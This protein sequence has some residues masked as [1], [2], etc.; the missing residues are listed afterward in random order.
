MVAHFVK[1]VT[2]NRSFSEN[3]VS[4]KSSFC[5]LVNDMCQQSTSFDPV[6]DKKPTPCYNSLMLFNHAVTIDALATPSFASG[7]ASIGN[8]FPQVTLPSLAGGHEADVQAL[9]SD[10]SAIGRDLQ[11]VLKSYANSI[12]HSRQK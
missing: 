8:L 6:I 11:Q 12:A 3:S 9:T 5:A 2:D 4:I 7:F 1:N 10:W